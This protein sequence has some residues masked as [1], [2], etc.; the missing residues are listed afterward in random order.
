MAVTDRETRV[1][2]DLRPGGKKVDPGPLTFPMPKHVSETPQILTL[3][4]L[5]SSKLSTYIGVGIRRAQDYADVVKLI[6]VN[7][8]PREF[9]IDPGVRGEYRKIWDG[10]HP[11]ADPV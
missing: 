2:V 8:L 1:E 7:R 4:K 3:D 6:E 5:I 10:L 11:P 9:G